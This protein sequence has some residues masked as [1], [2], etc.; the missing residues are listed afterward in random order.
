[1]GIKKIKRLIFS[2]GS[3]KG[4]AYIGSL[5]Y[6]EEHKEI[7]EDV[8]EYVGTSIG[9]LMCMVIVI[10][11]TSSELK[12]IFWDI[13][14]N[15]YRDP[16]LKTFFEAY[17]LDNGDKLVCLLKELISKKGFREDITLKELHAITKKSII[18]CVTNVNKKSTEY[19]TKENYPDIPVYLAVKTSMT[20]PLIFSPVEYNGSL[21]V[22]GALTNDI[23]VNFPN[24]YEHKCLCLCLDSNK[25]DFYEIKKIEDYMYNIFK[26]CFKINW[27]NNL[28]F[29]KESN[30]DVVSI[31]T[32][33][34][35]SINFHLTVEQKEE[36]Y[37]SG[38]NY[39]KNFFKL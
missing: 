7:F 24:K 6:I 18:A 30:I 4:I 5:K 33:I 22:D 8:I 23:P 35:T 17:G 1:M 14:L 13:D 34:I 10:G 16:S 12:Q 21:F 27:D 9:A 26:S 20:L 37:K 25:D 38:Y 32:D 39:I 29:A 11:Y 31:K 15:S 19:F 36:L 28:K 3:V 2:G